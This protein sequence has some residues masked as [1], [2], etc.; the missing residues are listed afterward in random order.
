LVSDV[1]GRILTRIYESKMLKRVFVLTRDEIIGGWRKL[2]NSSVI[3]Q[4][5]QI[6]EVE[7]DRACSVHRGKEECM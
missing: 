6:K 4:N 5:D 7:V 3:H 2:N 1:K